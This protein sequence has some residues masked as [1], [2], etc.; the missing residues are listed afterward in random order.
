VLRRAFFGLFRAIVAAD[1]DLFAAD[2]D[3]DSL[4]FDIPV[5]HGAFFGLHE[6]LLEIR[7]IESRTATIAGRSHEE[8]LAGIEIGDFQILA[9]LAER[10]PSPALLRPIF[11]TSEGGQ[12][13]SRWK[14]SVK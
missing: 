13:N 14:A 11:R 9:H 4:V 10:S 7:V 3:F 6:P 2:F 5:A 12:P 1:D 8:M